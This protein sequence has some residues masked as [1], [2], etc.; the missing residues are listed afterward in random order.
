MNLPHLPPLKFAQNVLFC[1]DTKARVACRF[2]S[3]PTLAMLVEACAQSSAA[4]ALEELKSGFL[5]G[6]DEMILHQ[7]CD[8]LDVEVALEKYALIGTMHAFTCQVFSRDVL[9]ASGRVTLLIETPQA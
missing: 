8:A 3:S 5:I 9:V 1:D 6:I 2:P 4:F 7:A